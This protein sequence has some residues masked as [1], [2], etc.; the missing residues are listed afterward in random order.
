[1]RFP[2]AGYFLALTWIG[3]TRPRLAAILRGAPWGAIAARRNAPDLDALYALYDGLNC[4][5]PTDAGTG[6]DLAKAWNW[7]DAKTLTFVIIASV[8]GGRFAGLLGWG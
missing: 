7:K 8:E 6:A 1:M 2:C 3:P 4:T 5:R